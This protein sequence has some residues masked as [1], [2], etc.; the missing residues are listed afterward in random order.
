VDADACGARGAPPPEELSSMYTRA[1]SLDGK[2]IALEHLGQLN[3]AWTGGILARLIEK[4][5]PQLGQENVYRRSSSLTA[6][7]AKMG[8]V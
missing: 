5:P 3:R 6:L 8:S 2:S 7:I 1:S 4:L